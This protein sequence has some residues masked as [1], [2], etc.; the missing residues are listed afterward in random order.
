M[1]D[2]I[3]KAGALDLPTARELFLSYA[4][5]LAVDLSYQ[6]F[7]EEVAGLP[8]PYASPS[9]ALLLALDE[10]GNGLGCVGVRTLSPGI[11]ELKRLYVAPARRGTG[12]G[13]ALVIAAIDEA[14]TLGFGEIRLDTLP[15]M[16]AAQ[17]LYR[18]L[19]F[20][21]IA[22]YYQPTPPGTVFMRLAL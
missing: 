11:A 7:D 20:Q 4:A 5:S 3:E 21:E 12:L 14:R 13:R 1:A 8:G 17:S 6:R 18:R 9:G 15:T 16:A 19:G 22:P 2:R 10:S